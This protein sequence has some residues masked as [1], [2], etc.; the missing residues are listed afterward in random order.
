MNWRKYITRLKNKGT[1][2][3]IASSTIL[4]LTNFGMVIE[5]DKVM[6]SVQAICSIGIA[7]GVLNNPD[8]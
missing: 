2:I 4:V 5:S 1:I 7:V 6:A 8:E 3:A